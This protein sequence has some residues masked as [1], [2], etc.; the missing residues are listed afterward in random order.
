MKLIHASILIPLF[1]LQPLLSQQTAHGYLTLTGSATF[2][3][4]YKRGNLDDWWAEQTTDP[5]RAVDQGSP[6]FF[7]LEAGV[8]M[9]LTSDAVRMGAT[10]GFILPASHALWGTSLFYGGRQELVLK[11]HIISIGMPF[12]FQLA[13]IEGLYAKVHP[14]L[15]MGW[16]TGSYSTPSYYVDIVMSP[17]IG[18]GLAGSVQ[19]F[20]TDMIGV[21]FTLGFRAV[22]GGLTIK[23]SESPTG[24]S[25]YNLDNGDEVKVGLGGM[26]MTYGIVARLP[27]FKMQLPQ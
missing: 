20:F 23:D 13:D 1:L 19:Y 3:N 21:D 11:P 15:L 9:P 22:K 17:G 6:A 18:F 10:F 7:A 4:S 12:M 25:I 2:R 26:Y 5:G 8:S 24:Y 14:A 16:V 27:A